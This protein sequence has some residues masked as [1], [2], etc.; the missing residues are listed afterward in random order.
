MLRNF[1]YSV[2]L[3]AGSQGLIGRANVNEIATLEVEG[4]PGGSSAV[5]EPS[6]AALAGLGVAF[7]GWLRRRKA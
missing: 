5:P 2:Y 6:T 4:I 7:A 3:K 1:P